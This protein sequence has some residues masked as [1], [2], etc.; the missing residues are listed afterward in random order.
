LLKSTLFIPEDFW[1]H[2]QIEVSEAQ[3][4]RLKAS[5]SILFSLV[6]R[7]PGLYSVLNHGFRDQVMALPQCDQTVQRFALDITD[8]LLLC[9]DVPWNEAQMH[10]VAECHKDLVH[11]RVVTCK[12]KL[13]S[14]WFD[15]NCRIVF[16]AA[17]FD[18]SFD[19]DTVELLERFAGDAEANFC[20]SL[21][22][23]CPESGL[24]TQDSGVT[25]RPHTEVNRYQATTFRFQDVITRRFRVMGPSVLF[26]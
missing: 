24:L 21:A 3:P 12:W 13:S 15:M 1:Q 26:A 8:V 14:L 16:G 4:F 18:S 25:L 5:F 2:I 11:G 19:Q 7:L 17:T 23:D 20:G 22:E 9:P 10:L 6:L